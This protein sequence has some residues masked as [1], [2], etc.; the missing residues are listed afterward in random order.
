VSTNLYVGNLT[1]QV[2]SADLENLF[3]DFGEVS[4]AQVIADRDTGRSRGFGFVEMGSAEAAQAAIAALD[5]KDFNGRKLTVNVA[6]P[7]SMQS[8]RAR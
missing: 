6:K 5:G 1:F 8:G 2:N 7:R 4:T 3:K